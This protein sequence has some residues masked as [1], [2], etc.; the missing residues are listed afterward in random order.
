MLVLA[1]TARQR[2]ASPW[3]AVDWQT[4]PEWPWHSASDDSPDQLRTIWQDA[5]ARSR[6][7]VTEA[8]DDGGLERLAQWSWADGGVPSLRWILCHMIEEYAR[9]N[10][11]A[12]FLRESVDG[13]TGE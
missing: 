9:H 5:A 13:L 6:A 2:P 7:L 4:D 10:G 8:L 3:D 1:A 12:D 11:R